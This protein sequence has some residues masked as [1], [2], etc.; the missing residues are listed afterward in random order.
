MLP[1]MKSMTSAQCTDMRRAATSGMLDLWALRAQPEMGA[2]GW[3]RKKPFQPGPGKVNKPMCF[4]APASFAAAGLT[5]LIGAIALTR[6]NEPRELPL[7]ATPLFF[8]LHQGVEGLLWLN[9]SL[10]PDGHLSAALTFI[11]LFFAEAFWPAYAPFAVWLIEPS[12]RR[13][14]LM[15]ICFGA[16]AAVGTYLLW[17]ILAHPLF[18]TI[19]DHHI[20]YWT[21]AG[22]PDAVRLAYL[23]ATGV[24]LLLSSHRTVNVFGAIVLAGLVVAYAF[25]WEALVSVWCFFAAV[26]SV[27][28]LY[29]F[30]WSRR[31]RLRGAGA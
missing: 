19:R 3:R 9:L 12:A 16:G 4:S 6:V 24:P 30:E 25:Y 10:A 15:V 13:R 2:N 5:G 23:A 29:H 28:I 8:A 11:Y 14:F 17:W 20:L 22:Q 18:A 27:V 7:A 21:G 31:H 26:A 1:T